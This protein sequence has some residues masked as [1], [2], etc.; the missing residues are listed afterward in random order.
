MLDGVELRLTNLYGKVHNMTVQMVVNET[1][2]WG[3]IYDDWT[4]DG[5]LGNIV[6]DQADVGL[7]AFQ[8]PTL[9]LRDNLQIAVYCRSF[10]HV[11]ARIALFG[12][13]PIFRPGRH[14]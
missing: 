6:T 3:E 11:A 7:G 12:S 8:F 2:L 1:A 14:D 9:V 13:V 5:I 10:V 4:G